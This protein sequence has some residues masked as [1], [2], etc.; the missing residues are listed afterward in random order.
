MSVPGQKR[1]SAFVIAGLLC[2]Q[3]RSLPLKSAMKRLMHRSERDSIYVAPESCR[4]SFN[5]P[6]KLA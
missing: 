1:K 4:N 2:P 6:E 3:Y 5:Q